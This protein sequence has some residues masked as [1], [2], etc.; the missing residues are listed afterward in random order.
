MSMDRIEEVT[1][2][3]LKNLLD[4]YD[5]DMPIGI[6]YRYGDHWKSTG[7]VVPNRAEEKLVKWSPNLC[8]IVVD[9]SEDD[10]G[11]PIL[12]SRPWLILED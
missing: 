2:G 12:H 9:E 8:T 3:Q 1:V 4:D 11:K 10:D 6:G 7:V 5:D